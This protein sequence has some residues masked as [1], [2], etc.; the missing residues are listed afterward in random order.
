MPSI[1]ELIE[2]IASV[3]Q[4]SQQLASRAL[5]D[6]GVFMT[7]LGRTR[8]EEQSVSRLLNAVRRQRSRP[9]CAMGG[10]PSGIDRVLTGCCR[11]ALS[12]SGRTPGRRSRKSGF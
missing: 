2:E 5:A 4:P 9:E 8:A 1:Q 10:A 3:R 11:Q 7:A 6:A 12:E